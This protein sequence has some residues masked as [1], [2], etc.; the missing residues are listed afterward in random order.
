MSFSSTGMQPIEFKSDDVLSDKLLNS[1]T[2]KFASMDLMDDTKSPPR[3]VSNS[4]ADQV[5]LMGDQ[6]VN[7]GKGDKN[8]NLDLSKVNQQ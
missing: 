7:N 4:K 2:S 8:F 6:G 5:A 1:Q 3:L